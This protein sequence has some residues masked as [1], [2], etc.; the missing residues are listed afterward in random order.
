MA[1]SEQDFDHPGPAPKKSKRECKYQQSWKGHGMLPSSKGPT[2]THCKI[3]K[4][5]IN[6]G[7]GGL[8]DVKKHLAT[9]KHK[10]LVKAASSSG[11]VRTFLQQV[12]IEEKIT[13]AEVLFANFVAEHNLPFLTANHFTR[14]TSVMF[15]DSSIA[16]AFSSARTKTTCIVKGAL[17]PHFAEPVISQ[18]KKC[19]FSILCD[20]GNDVDDKNFAILVRLWDDEQGRPVTRFLDMPVCNIGTAEKLFELIDASM[21]EKGLTWSN[22]VGFESDTTN[23]MVGKHNSVLSRVKAKQPKVYSQ[24]CVCHLANLCLLA[25]VKALP[26][27][28]DDFFVDLFYYFDKSAK[29]KEELREFQDFTDTKKLKIIKHCKTRWLSLERVVKRVLQQWSAYFDRVSE[30]DSSCGMANGKSSHFDPYR[31]NMLYSAFR[32]CV[33][34]CV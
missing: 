18:C 5:H 1:D 22:V 17:H 33:C 27:D 4:A 28:V 10:E 19:P 30:S 34:V 26:V 24:G 15:P 8:S 29:R 12:P 20:E 14:L 2:F 6:I 7:H 31:I 16:Q 3:C 32:V 11:N 13:R 25:G 21:T 23:V 9:S